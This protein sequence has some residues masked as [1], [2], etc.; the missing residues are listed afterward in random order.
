MVGGGHFSALG[1]R[2]TPRR[3]CS[4]LRNCKNRP[5]GL[6]GGGGGSG[7][8]GGHASPSS[9]FSEIEFWEG[10]THLSSPLNHTLSHS[11][12]GRRQ[13]GGT[14]VGGK[15]ERGEGGGLKEGDKVQK[16]GSG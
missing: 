7:S 13:E 3:P 5:Q 4:L 16:D 10:R 15:R 9:S 1:S 12:R 6:L 11:L 2:A 14:G 8:G